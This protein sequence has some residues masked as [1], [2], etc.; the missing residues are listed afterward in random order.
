MKHIPLLICN[1]FFGIQFFILESLYNRHD[2]F[3]IW[4][5]TS[6]R[7]QQANVKFPDLMQH[8]FFF[9]WLFIFIWFHKNWNYQCNN[10]FKKGI[11][12]ETQSTFSYECL[13]LL[14]TR[15]DRV[16]YVWHGYQLHS[17]ELKDL[18]KQKTSTLKTAKSLVNWA[19]N[20]VW[21][22]SFCGQTSRYLLGWAQ[23]P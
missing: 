12:R 16:K 6:I 8:Y 11:V 13:L 17:D 18:F 20:L 1:F 4:L 9:I 22:D 15:H 2:A 23:S 5:Q 21:S 19:V 7:H 10:L 3:R 14:G